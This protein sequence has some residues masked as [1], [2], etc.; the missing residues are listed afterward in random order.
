MD[1]ERL[2]FEPPPR[3]A[4]QS[5]ELPLALLSNCTHVLRSPDPSNADTRGP[6]SY[7]AA[8][9]RAD[10]HL[11]KARH[12]A[13]DLGGPCAQTEPLRPAAEQQLRERGA[14]LL[15]RAAAHVLAPDGLQLAQLG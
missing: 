13:R 11:R 1:L 5:Q 12:E 15:A 9:P 2:T 7:P 14:I 6:D 4:A 3:A 8:Q 10:P